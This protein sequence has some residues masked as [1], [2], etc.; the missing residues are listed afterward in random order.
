MWLGLFEDKELVS[1]EMQRVE[2]ELLLVEKD[3]W[4]RNK[5]C[6]PGHAKAERTVNIKQRGKVC[7]GAAWA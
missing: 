1:R 3:W 7:R 4:G 6:S 5:I 2:G